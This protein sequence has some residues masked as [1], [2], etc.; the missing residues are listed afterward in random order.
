MHEK[1]PTEVRKKQIA[2]AAQEII[3]QQGLGKFTTSAIARA[4]GISEGALF[5]H[6]KN[7]EEIIQLVIDELE[8]T[9][10]RDWPP[11]H[12]DPLKRLGM[13]VESRIKLLAE[14]PATM[15]LF[16]SDQLMQAAGPG[17]VERIREMERRSMEFVMSC[18]SEAEQKDMLKK[19]IHIPHV[20]LMI[21][22]S[23]MA[24]VSL[25]HHQNQAMMKAIQQERQGL[26]Q[27]LETLIR[28]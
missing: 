7:K 28:R 18:I 22:G 2:R 16:F 27:T 25:Q 3:A 11:Q 13:F 23:I 6:V 15:Q 21:F 24:A 9:L 5:R 14:A 4:V 8:D 26:W 20:L 19:D 1:Q 10:F 17:G 12:P